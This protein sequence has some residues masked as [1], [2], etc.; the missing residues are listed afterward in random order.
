MPS[1]E[2]CYYHVIFAK[3]YY[4]SVVD[5][6]PLLCVMSMRTLSEIKE[7]SRVFERNIQEHF[8]N[9]RLR[10]RHVGHF[11]DM[12]T[13]KLKISSTYIIEATQQKQPD[14]VR[15]KPATTLTEHDVILYWINQPVA[16]GFLLI[17][18]LP[19]SDRMNGNVNF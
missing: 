5:I 10:L 7:H 2:S 12:L 4:N 8:G 13:R 9:L 18:H 16:V 14:R 17:R 3:Y 1:C 6:S 11:G 15:G 19:C